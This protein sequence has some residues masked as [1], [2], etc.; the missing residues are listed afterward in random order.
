M[1]R[2]RLTS[3]GESSNLGGTETPSDAP[4]KFSTEDTPAVFSRNDSLSSL[5]YE[6][7]DANQQK[8]AVKLLEGNFLTRYGMGTKCV[9][10]E[11]GGG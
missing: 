7:S 5:E 6:D 11:G 8:G 9:F 1:P 4:L 3:G 2:S 10:C